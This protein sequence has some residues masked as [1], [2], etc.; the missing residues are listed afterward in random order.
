M[1]WKPAPYQDRIV[2]HILAHPA[3]AVWARVGSGKTSA[4]LAA[5]DV[6]RRKGGFS[7]L[8]LAPKHVALNVWAQE[9]AKWDEFRHLKVNVLHGSKKHLLLRE[10]A[11][12]YVLNY[13]GL[14]WL[15]KESVH[16]WVCPPVLVL[17]ESSKCRNT[18]TARFKILRDLAPRFRRRIALSGTPMPNGEVNLFG[19]YRLLDDGARLGKYITHFRN[20]YMYPSGYGGYD[21]QLL[22]GAA[23]A[24]REAVQDITVEVSAAD[25]GSALPKLVVRDIEVPLPPAA[26]RVYRTLVDQFIVRLKKGEVT[27]VNAAAQT[28]KMRQIASGSVYTEHPAWEAVHD[29]RLDALDSLLEEATGSVLTFYEFAHE[30]ERIRERFERAVD[31]TSLTDKRKQQCILD[32]NA[33]K[34]PLLIAHPASAGHGLNLQGGGNTVVWFSLL[35]DLEL[36]DQSN[37]RLQRTGQK[38]KQVFVHRFVSPDTLDEVMVNA[39][40][41][42]GVNQEQFLLAIRR[43]L[44]G[45]DSGRIAS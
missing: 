32:W 29:A 30:A 19:Q 15:A 33:G 10:R 21:W 41:S 12:I 11:D 31:F 40:D 8:V 44:L 14:P 7:A 43:H 13:D 38:A 39:L 37:G 1:R 28:Q 2:R 3:A 35:Y 17:D 18:D 9:A 22:P 27:A 42:K 5:L 26:E 20:K 16:G 23:D 34:I 45:V 4:T 36:Y 25:L 24:I 6:M